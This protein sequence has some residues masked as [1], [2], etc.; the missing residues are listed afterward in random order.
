MPR[1]LIDPLDRKVIVCIKTRWLGVM[2]E[3]FPDCKS[4]DEYIYLLKQKIA[5][6]QGA[7]DA[8]ID[9]DNKKGE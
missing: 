3:D 8:R 9:A 4:V 2:L 1:K 6:L 5:K 7:I